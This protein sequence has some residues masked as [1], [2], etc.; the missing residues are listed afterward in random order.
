MSSSS[1]EIIKQTAIW[2]LL[3][4]DLSLYRKNG[5]IL[6]RAIDIPISSSTSLFNVFL[7][8]DKKSFEL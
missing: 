8:T 6:L 5:S 2:F 3:L 4:V 7:Q 1:T